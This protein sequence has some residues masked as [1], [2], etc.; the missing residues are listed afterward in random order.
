MHGRC[1]FLFG[2]V[3]HGETSISEPEYIPQ[4]N[5]GLFALARIIKNS[6]ILSK[7]YK[8]FNKKS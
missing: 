8:S 4:K 2:A 7:V 3:A 1:D 5:Y 6:C